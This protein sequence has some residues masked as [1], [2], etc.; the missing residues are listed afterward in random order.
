M[1]RHLFPPNLARTAIVALLVAG[2]GVSA[3]FAIDSG[4]SSSGGTSAKAAGPDV[5]N[6]MRLART[7][8]DKGR[9][10]DAISRLRAVVRADAR[11]ADAYNLL[12][13]S[14]RKI[15]KYDDAGKYYDLALRYQPAHL[16]A[17]E[18]QG[19]LFLILHHPD[20]ASANLDKLQKACG[21]TCEEYADL[22]AAIA[23]YKSN[24]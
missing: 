8:I 9:Y 11:N 19:E 21:G 16:G 12:G 5:A 6:E 15:K 23:R 1:F 22:K 14:S 17:L 2:A 10:Q 7:D 24:S 20:K 3:S 13:F 4:K 18:Y